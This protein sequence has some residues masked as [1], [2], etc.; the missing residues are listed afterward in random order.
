MQKKE[1][2]LRYGKS[3]EHVQTI[4][5]ADIRV[6]RQVPYLVGLPY[7]CNVMR[8]MACATLLQLARRAV[9]G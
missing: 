5:Q 7:I 6:D 8:S 2:D 1:R 4:N 3:T 9:A